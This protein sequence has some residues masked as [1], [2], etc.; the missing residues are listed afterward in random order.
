[1]RSSRFVAAILAGLVVACGSETT[2]GDPGP[3]AAVQLG[4]RPFYLLDRL[5]PGPLRSALERC[6][7]GPFRPSRFSIGHR[8]APLQF[9][10]HTEESYRAAARMGA[11]ILECDVVFTKDRELVCRHAQ[12]DLHSTTNILL[13]PLAARCRE[14]FQPAT[15]D[16]DSG[17]L[18]RPASARCCTSE[19][20]LAEFAS[21]EGRMEAGDPRATTAEA[22]LAGIPAFRTRLYEDSGTLLS[23]AES[24]A[25]FEELGVGMAPELKTPEVPMP[26]EGAYTQRDYASQLIAE[27][28]DAGIDPARVWP[29]SFLREDVLGWIET[30]PEFGRQAVLL[31]EDRPGEPGP[32]DEQLEALKAA[33]VNYLAPPIPALLEARAGRIQATPLARRARRAG[34][35]LIAWTLER[36]GRI[37]SDVLAGGGDYYHRSVADAIRD[38]GAVLTTLHALASEAGVVGV[39]SD[40]PATTT[41]YASCFDLE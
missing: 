15:F 40:W 38:D 17:R 24:I 19:L 26:F 9:P 10:E 3:A 27:Y 23:H 13:T 21:L 4:P 41:F 29:Q 35:S 20:T 36:S 30:A 7:Q 18:V 34:L 2:G 22:F 25:L 39:F 31:I 32:D 14:P 37:R 1:M 16:P 6:R 8:G 11:G 5:D 33:G 28:R 12:C